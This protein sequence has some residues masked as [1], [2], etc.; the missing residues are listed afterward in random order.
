MKFSLAVGLLSHAFPVFSE[1]GSDLWTSSNREVQIADLLKS[2]PNPQWHLNK[3]QRLNRRSILR[4]Q[5][6]IRNSPVVPDVQTFC[7]PTSTNADI[8]ILSCGK[9]RVCIPYSES[10]LGGT[11][12]SIA[13]RKEQSIITKTLV[14]SLPSGTS[15]E[16]DPASIDIG[17]LACGEGEFCERAESSKLGGFCT[18]NLT[19][20][21]RLATLDDYTYMCEPSSPDSPAMC[22]CSGLNMTSGTGIMDCFHDFTY[23][24]GCD[25]LVIYNNFTYTFEL[26]VPT[27]LVDCTEIIVPSYEKVCFTLYGENLNETCQMEFNGES[28]NSCV[29]ADYFYDFD[30]SNLQAGLVGSTPMELSS[31]I[32]ACYTE[33][34][35]TCTSFCGDGYY[36]AYDKFG[37]N[38]TFEGYDVPCGKLAYYEANSLVPDI[39]CPSYI[40]AAQSGCCAPSNA[41]SSASPSSGPGDIVTP[42]P[43]PDGS[44][45]GSTAAL[46]PMKGIQVIL[47]LSAVTLMFL[48]CT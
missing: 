29:K 7:D 27:K 45:T 26:T 40:A 16:C 23:F 19:P 10:Y 11:C 32:A 2:L 46:Q 1:K 4:S 34:S 21:R 39:K 15:V 44:S 41:T 14:N 13:P 38:V 35:Y 25:E 8:G 31:I 48:M 3:R 18:P 33:P 37:I 43:S 9:G 42:A 22:D 30:C 12:A 24:Y 6:P 47:S 36:M 17:I 20:S 28:C 5:L